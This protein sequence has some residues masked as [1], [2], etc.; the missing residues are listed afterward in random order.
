MLIETV[1]V[2]QGL[3]RLLMHFQ[4]LNQ[5]L[6]STTKRDRNSLKLT[7]SDIFHFLQLRQHWFHVCYFHLALRR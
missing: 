5:R 7:Q 1:K 6:E 4:N 3:D 2:F